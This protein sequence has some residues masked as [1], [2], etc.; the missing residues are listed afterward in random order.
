MDKQSRAALGRGARVLLLDDSDIALDF[1]K[2]LL[3]RYGFEVRVS[4]TLT[5]LQVQLD[6]WKP[7]AIVSDLD[8]PDADA[9]D[10]ILWLR[11]AEGTAGIPIVICSGQPLADLR[12]VAAERGAD[13]FVS[14][15]ENVNAL[16]EAV[17][18]AIDGSAG[19]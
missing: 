8:L 7:E 11:K 4:T 10:V 19:Q 17:R 15:A 6:G 2:R 16:P 12:R 18:S 1:E 3:E 9:G 13:G 5:E 14:K